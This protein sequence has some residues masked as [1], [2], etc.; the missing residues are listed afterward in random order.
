MLHVTSQK[1]RFIATFSGLY[2]VNGEVTFSPLHVR[3]ADSVVVYLYA[4]LFRATETD[5][6]AYTGCAGPIESPFMDNNE[7]IK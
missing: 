7:N 3:H 6:C 1:L 4:R 2:I 5:V